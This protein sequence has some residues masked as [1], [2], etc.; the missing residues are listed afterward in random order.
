MNWIN[1]YVRPTLRR[2][3]GQSDTPDNLWTKCSHCGQM[4]YIATLKENLY[5]CPHCDAH[6]RM[7]V[8][9]RL[10]ALFDNAAYDSITLPQV[11]D[12][13]LKFR[14]RKPYP[15]RLREYRQKTGRNDVFVVAQGT[16]GGQKL[17]IAAMDFAFMGGSL[18]RAGGEALI[19]AARL[20][21]AQQA[22]LLVVTASGGAR[23]Q[24]GI[25]SLMQLPRSIVAI[26]MVKEA[27]LPYLVLLSDPTTGGVSASYAMLGDIHLAEPGATIGFAG[28]RVIAQ[29]IREAL[30][31]GFQTAEYL[32]S[33]GMLDMV[34]HRREL[35]GRI[36]LIIDL[37][38]LPGPK[39][40]VLPPAD[41][42]RKTAGVS[43]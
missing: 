3:T 33:H 5:V 39:A 16:C 43:G 28:A 13:P 15:A 12:D 2:F 38:T 27:G 4:I 34:V 21:V 40:E 11:N 18:S 42:G 30:P 6:L 31:E 1:N 10:A 7:P 17:V 22:P 32:R 25:L 35:A 8:E 37:L 36:A 29:T 41:Q 26:D 24:E 14:D 9:D 19:A 23:M 20:A